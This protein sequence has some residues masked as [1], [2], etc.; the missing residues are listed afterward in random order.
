MR[1]S[2]D[3]T[4]KALISRIEAARKTGKGNVSIACGGE[5]YVRVI[6]AK[7]NVFWYRRDPQKGFIRLAELT[8]V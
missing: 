5:L 4:W 8:R 3:I 2:T 1:P 6:G 7:Q